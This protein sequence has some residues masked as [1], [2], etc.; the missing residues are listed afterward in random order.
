MQ[1]CMHVIQGVTFQTRHERHLRTNPTQPTNIR[2]LTEESRGWDVE[3]V[4]SKSA[5]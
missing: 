5:A 2:S 3:L 1:A 4:V